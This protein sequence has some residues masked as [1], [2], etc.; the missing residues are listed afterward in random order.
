MRPNE[1]RGVKTGQATSETT[2]NDRP[3]KAGAGRVSR[4][5]LLA[6]AALTTIACDWSISPPAPDVPPDCAPRDE[7]CACPS[8]V[9]GVLRVC[10]WEWCEC[11]PRMDGGS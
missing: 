5:R 9:T 10:R 11:P 1:E 3:W 8:G 4:L 6:F 7:P 2:S